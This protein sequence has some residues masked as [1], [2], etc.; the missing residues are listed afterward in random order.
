MLIGSSYL[1][2]ETLASNVALIMLF[3]ELTIWGKLV[4]LKKKK[5]KEMVVRLWWW[6]N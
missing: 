6:G 1:P 2:C 4:W 5:K 3:K